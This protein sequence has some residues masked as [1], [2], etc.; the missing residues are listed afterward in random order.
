MI[1]RDNCIPFDD[2]AEVYDETRFLP[3]NVHLQTFDKIIKRIARLELRGK[4]EQISF[5][6]AGCGSGRLILPFIEQLCLYLRGKKKPAPKKKTYKPF[7]EKES[8]SCC[9]EEDYKGQEDLG[10]FKE[11]NDLHF[12]CLDISQ[13]MI[14]KFED[15]L[16][17]LK[18][19]PVEDR[20]KKIFIKPIEKGG[21]D[22]WNIH[23]HLIQDDL[24]TYIPDTSNICFDVVFAHWIF[25]VIKDWHLA[26]LNIYDLSSDNGLLFTFNENSELYDVIDNKLTEIEQTGDPISF[27]KTY[28]NLRTNIY[29][30]YGV[31]IPPA[32]QRIG[33]NVNDINIDYWVNKL[34]SSPEKDEEKIG[35]KDSWKCRYTESMI[36]SEI[37][38]KRAF[39]NMRLGKDETLKKIYEDIANSLLKRSE[40]E[41]TTRYFYSTTKF[42]AS[43]YKKKDLDKKEK[44]SIFKEMAKE[45][46]SKKMPN[47]LF[48]IP[49]RVYRKYTEELIEIIGKENHFVGIHFFNPNNS[50]IDF[51]EKIEESIFPKK[52]KSSKL[53]AIWKNLTIHSDL[54]ISHYGIKFIDVQQVE[55]K[56][57][58]KKNLEV[59]LS[60]TKKDIEAIDELIASEGEDF[61][62]QGIKNND[63]LK[64]IRTFILKEKITDSKDEHVVAFFNGLHSLYK[65]YQHK[66]NRYFYFFPNLVYTPIGNCKSFGFMLYSKKELEP[67]CDIMQNVEELNDL[68]FGNI[69]QDLQT[70]LSVNVPVVVT[71]HNNTRSL[72]KLSEIKEK[73]SCDILIVTCT[74]SEFEQAIKLAGVPKNKKEDRNIEW[75]TH[76]ESNKDKKLPAIY[77]IS[78]ESFWG[79][80]VWVFQTF[81][82]GDGGHGI[83]Y[84]L[85]NIFE[86]IKKSKKKLPKLIIMGG[87]AAGLRED[88]GQIRGQILLASS[89]QKVTI[90]SNQPQAEQTISKVKQSVKKQI[91]PLIT[92]YTDQ[93]KNKTLYSQKIHTG[94]ILSVN[95]VVNN[96]SLK[97]KIKDM[98][99]K[100][101]GLEMEGDGLAKTCASQNINWLLI[102]GI[103]DFAHQK[104]EIEDYQKNIAKNTFDFIYYCLENKEFKD[105][106]EQLDSRKCQ[107]CY[108]PKHKRG[109]IK[110][111]R[112]LS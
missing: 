74:S 42:Q 76:L 41:N 38:K 6:E 73:D 14:K 86:H 39:S 93:I 25:H 43:H 40:E 85:K 101:I 87:I 100:S 18:W 105:F 66:K 68:I 79:Q 28:F 82:T 71:S 15:K 26:L 50:K 17:N 46:L 52:I 94:L 35:E 19:R 53:M 91:T 3:R 16:T 108:K 47:D 54:G 33:A 80:K 102:K 45:S 1:S 21:E 84:C 81:E 92:L 27:W 34:Y 56:Q 60:I 13:K 103:S 2:I 109:C 106:I 24:R 59:V 48:S 57:K 67:E 70:D 110:K 36:S 61:T 78:Q 30:Y 69:T 12:Y 55:Q 77:D 8:L 44:L 99:E 64:Q 104:D 65:L 72:N 9:N 37:I 5:L 10:I 62:V 23:I 75:P 107:N 11:C 29:A 20:G 31:S 51:R 7:F 98:L 89:V 111:N 49:H 88:N 22:S 90:V 97:T 96:Y 4:Q 63:N 83:S 32:K 95:E 112:A 58:E